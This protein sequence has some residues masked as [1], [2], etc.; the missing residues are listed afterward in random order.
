[1]L[2]VVTADSAEELNALIDVDYAAWTAEG[3]R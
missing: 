3:Q 2:S 1:V